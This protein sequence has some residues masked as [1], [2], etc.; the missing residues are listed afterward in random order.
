V[1]NEARRFEKKD[2]T[3]I[4]IG[5]PGHDETVGTMGWVRPE[6][7]HRVLTEEDVEALDL[8]QDTPLAYLTQTTLSVDDCE[9]VIQALKR[10]YPH[11]QGPPKSDICYATTNRQAAVKSIAP[12]VDL[13]LVVGDKESANSTRLAEICTSLGKPSYLISKAAMI[14]PEWLEGV[15]CILLTSGASAPETL[16][17]GVI[18]YLRQLGPVD[19]EETELIPE[20][21]HFKLPAELAPAR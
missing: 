8:T 6:R 17:Q 19:V 3:I 2:F 1:H 21:V 15:E 9:R 13:V 18:D 20:D 12:G 16:V 11:I 7:I 4:L 14:Q 5:E 10:K